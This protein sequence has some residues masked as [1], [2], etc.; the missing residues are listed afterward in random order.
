MKPVT[1]YMDYRRYIRD[2][3]AERKAVGFSWNAFAASA[4]LSSPVFLQYVCEGRKN[5]SEKTAARV[6]KAMGLVGYDVEFF[7][8]LVAYGNA[9]DEPAKKK[10]LER[11]SAFAETHKVRVTGADE[12]E[13][14]KSWKNSV[15]R[16]IAPAL[17]GATHKQ[18]SIASRRRIPTTEVSEILDFLWQA[19]YLEQDDS[20]NYRQT[21]RS[22]CMGATDKAVKTELQR[23]MAE[24]ALD[25]LEKE[26]AEKRNMTGLT[27]GVTRDK[28]AQIVAE[29]ADCRRRIVAIAASDDSTEEVYRLNMQ[30]FPL[31]DIGSVNS[32]STSRRKK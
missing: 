29:L 28:Y 21:N 16:E 19:G 15:V 24:L 18:L 1:E 11:I 6:A 23:Q 3:Y 32:T 2:Y 9:K 27:L 25:A 7:G 13:F 31:T 10:A 12:Y 20:G 26:P 22:L 8:L 5:L 4:G 14:F 30:L 17:P